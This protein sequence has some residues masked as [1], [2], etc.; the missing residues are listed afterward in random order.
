VARRLARKS[1]FAVAGLVSVH[2]ATWTT[3]RQSAAQRWSAIEPDWA[4][5]LRQLA[6]WSKSSVH[7]GAREVG[8]SLDG[9]VTHLIETF[10]ATVG[11]WDTS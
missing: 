3:D 5:H 9:A 8:T 4:T 7:V 11:L 1:L 6:N 10:D 2:N